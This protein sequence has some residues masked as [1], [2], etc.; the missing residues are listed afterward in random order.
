MREESLPPPAPT[1]SQQ[2]R[3]TLEENV[4]SLN[5]GAAKPQMAQPSLKN[6]LPIRHAPENPKKSQQLR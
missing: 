6:S 2:A 3:P 5:A 1:S 4:P